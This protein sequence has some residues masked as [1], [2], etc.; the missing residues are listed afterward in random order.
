[1]A[2]LIEL[3]WRTRTVRLERGAIMG[4]LNVTPDSFSDGGQFLGLNAAVEQAGAMTAAGAAIIDVGGE[5]TRPGAPVVTE[6][7]E[8]ERVLPVIEAINGLRACGELDVLISTDTRKPAVAR[9]ALRAGADLVNDVTG[10]RDPAMREVCAEFGVPAVLM[11]MRGTPE[12][13]KWSQEAQP[14]T[15]VVIEVRDELAALAKQAMHAGVPSVILDPGFGFGKSVEQNLELIRRLGE[16]RA[17]GYPLLLGASRKSTLG[18][19]TGVTA[20]E[21]RDPASIAAHLY[22]LMTGAD[23]LRVHDVAGHA[24]AVKVWQR[25]GESK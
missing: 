16:I 8:L 17:L 7:A 21:Q 19:I 5:S 9:A 13:L 18:R 25:L 14:F 12:T 3:R 11:H 2:E 4:V 15:D 20:S 1:M 23:I 10:L 22:G 24:Q 6:E